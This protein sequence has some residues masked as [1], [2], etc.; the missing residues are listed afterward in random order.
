[1]LAPKD[2]KLPRR[3]KIK[4]RHEL[5]KNKTTRTD[6]GVTKLLISTFIRVSAINVLRLV[7]T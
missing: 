2:I 6:A 5:G 4:R 7:I 3:P 1:M